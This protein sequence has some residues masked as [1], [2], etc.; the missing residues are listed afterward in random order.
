MIIN[1]IYDFCKNHNNDSYRQKE[2]I[3]IGVDIIINIV[4]ILSAC[5]CWTTTQ[6]SVLYKLVCSCIAYI[7]N[8]FYILYYV[9]S[10]SETLE[11]AL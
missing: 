10:P 1:Y 11:P 5:L 4:S 7:F 2:F 3:D 6:G 9:Q 8:I